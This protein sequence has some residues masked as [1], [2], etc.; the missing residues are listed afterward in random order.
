MTAAGGLILALICIAP[1]G[2]AAGIALATWGGREPPWLV[3]AARIVAVAVAAFC[4][5]LA[6]VHQLT[7]ALLP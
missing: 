3:T 7:E 2:L 1:V 4:F 6:A 5:L